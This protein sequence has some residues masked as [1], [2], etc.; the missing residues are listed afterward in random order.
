M[1]PV[2]VPFIDNIS[3]LKYFSLKIKE[4]CNLILKA[5][6]EPG[7]FT[8]DGIKRFIITTIRTVKKS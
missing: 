3:E 2:S 5:E 4:P 1:L 7:Q 6:F 8:M